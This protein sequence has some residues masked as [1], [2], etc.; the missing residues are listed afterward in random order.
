MSTPY[1]CLVVLVVSPCC[2]TQP[3]L[4]WVTALQCPPLLLAA[5]SGLAPIG[6][7]CSQ[8][9]SQLCLGESS[10]WQ[11]VL[12]EHSLLQASQA[13]HRIHRPHNMPA[14]RLLCIGSIQK[15][16]HG[17]YILV[18]EKQVFFLVCTLLLPQNLIKNIE[19]NV[20]V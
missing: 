17:T 13:S 4:Q 3:V 14:C 1:C 15:V 5:Y 10:C 12:P 19:T 7:A 9:V 2:R 20:S 8:L 18:G 11:Q 16:T 6:P